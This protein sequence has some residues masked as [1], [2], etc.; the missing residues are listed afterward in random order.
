VTTKVAPL[1]LAKF[2]C[3]DCS[4]N[5]VSIGEFY[6]CPPRVWRDELGLSCDDNLCIGCLEKRLGRRVG[7]FIDIMPPGSNYSW[8]QPPS[9]RMRDRFGFKKTRKTQKA[10]RR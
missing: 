6:M 1:D 8:M 10:R 3:N 7:P 9:D 5:V 4:V 2:K